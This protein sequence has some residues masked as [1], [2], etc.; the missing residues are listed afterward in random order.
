MPAS[1]LWPLSPRPGYSFSQS[2]HTRTAIQNT[3]GTFG[4]NIFKIKLL[5]PGQ[6]GCSLARGSQVEGGLQMRLGCNHG[7][8]HTPNRSLG[9]L[10]PQSSWQHFQWW[11]CVRAAE[12]PHCHRHRACNKRL[13]SP[14]SDLRGEPKGHTLFWML[15]IVDPKLISETGESSKIKAKRIIYKFQ[16]TNIWSKGIY[17][18]RDTFPKGWLPLSGF[19]P[20][21]R[22]PLSFWSPLWHVKGDVQTYTQTRACR[23]ILKGTVTRPKEWEY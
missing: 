22:G 16:L 3:W 20:D 12:S 14:S 10:S 4:L 18:K 8:G 13:S 1:H 9:P 2:K 6:T 17:F 7:K 23:C 11:W 19:N 15:N 21:P 5:T